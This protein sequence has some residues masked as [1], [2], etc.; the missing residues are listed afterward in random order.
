MVEGDAGKVLAQLEAGNPNK[1]FNMA[2]FDGIEVRNLVLA[3]RFKAISGRH[4]QGGGFVWRF[5]D[6]R[7][8]YIVRANPL[9]NNVV[10]YQMQDGVRT[11]LPLA[12]K[13]RTYGVKVKELGR[14]WHT[15]KL[16][17]VE[18]EFTVFLDGEELFRVRDS[19]FTGAG[20]FG[21][22]TK[23]DAVTWFDD[24]SVQIRP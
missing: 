2:V 22:W 10:L 19:T 16:V 14:D 23:A 4:D 18:D 8:H 24:L 1:H 20:R 5:R 3:V 9:E 6:A 12:G 15:L 17:V 13:G 7:N 21:L 11:D